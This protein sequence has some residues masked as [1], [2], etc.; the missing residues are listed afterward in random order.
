MENLIYKIKLG[1]WDYFTNTEDISGLKKY[2][3]NSKNI[4]KLAK[5][6]SDRMNGKV[7]LSKDS[8]N[9]RSLFK[10]EELKILK[11]ALKMLMVH[12]LKIEL[13][14]IELKM[15]FKPDPRIE[16]AIKIHAKN[17]EDITQLK[18]ETVDDLK[19]IDKEIERREDK[20]K[21]RNKKPIVELSTMTFSEAV[22]IVFSTLGETINLDLVLNYFFIKKDKAIKLN[23]K[24]PKQ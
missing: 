18:I 3:V 8:D 10:I 4:I 23:E 17:L 2:G 21:E 6:V 7:D 20:Y 24:I 5:I 19:K 11:S 9:L 14:M 22:E 16:D 15:E 13:F 1:D 12:N